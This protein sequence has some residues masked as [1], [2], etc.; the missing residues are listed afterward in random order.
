[1]LESDIDEMEPCVL[2]LVELS[3]TSYFELDIYQF[4]FILGVP[5]RKIYS[6]LIF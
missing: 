4:T 3:P 1:M 5:E 6:V 2:S